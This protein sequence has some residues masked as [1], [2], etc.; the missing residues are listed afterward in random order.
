MADT[1]D[2]TLL[3][4]RNPSTELWKKVPDW[5]RKVYV[6]QFTRDGKKFLKVGVTDYMEAYDRVIFN[7]AIFKEGKEQDWVET[8]MYEYFD[9]IKIMASAMLTKD[10]ANKLEEVIL[11]NWGDQDLKL[12]K[13]KGMSEF[14]KYNYPRLRQARAIIDE[15]RYKG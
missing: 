15:N 14:R 4:K 11:T 2:K 1:L 10:K 3:E 8:T 12:P 7:H 6:F 13:M 5:A 9:D